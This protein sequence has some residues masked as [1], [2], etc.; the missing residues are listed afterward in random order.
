M[1][2]NSHVLKSLTSL[3]YLL[4]LVYTPLYITNPSCFSIPSHTGTYI[5]THTS[6][7]FSSHP[8]FLR[9]D[10]IMYPCCH[11]THYADQAGLE[12]TNPSVCLCLPSARIR[13]MYRHLWLSL[14]YNDWCCLIF[15]NYY[16]LCSS[17]TLTHL[18][19]PFFYTRTI[20]AFSA[21]LSL[22]LALTPSPLLTRT[23]SLLSSHSFSP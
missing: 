6:C 23:Q 19:S 14:L 20:V 9:Q 18:P 8:P 10:F 16:L 2:V 1:H 4:A 11:E 21:T 15:S 12:L 3:P 22:I 5:Y 7:W 13:V 17:L